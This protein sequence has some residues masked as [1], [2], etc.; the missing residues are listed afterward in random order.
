LREGSGRNSGREPDLWAFKVGYYSDGFLGYAKQPGKPTVEGL[1]EEALLRRKVIR[2]GDRILVASRTD[3]GVHAIGNVIAFQ[4]PL[5][6]RIAARILDSID[7]RFFCFGFARAPPD[8]LPRR[9]EERWYRYM[10]P[11]KGHDIKQWSAWAMEFEG[12]HDFTSFSR[13]DSP[14]KETR[15]TVT[16]VRISQSGPDFLLDIV[17][18]SFL[19]GQVRKIVAALMELEAGRMTVSDLSDALS[20]KRRLTLPLAPPERLV[21]MDV[22]YPFAFIPTDPNVPRRREFLESAV[23]GL[24]LRITLLDW[25]KERPERAHDGLPRQTVESPRQAGET[26]HLQ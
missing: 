5:D 18:P 1:L 23:E 25:F 3:R 17:A 26:R 24:K 6:G 20:G 16:S 12:T 11:G 13:K 21:L 4:T 10:M 8:F 2:R 15:R 7:G 22:T 9:A 14:P 19:W